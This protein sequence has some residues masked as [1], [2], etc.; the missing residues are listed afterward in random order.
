M[1]VERTNF[2]QDYSIKSHFIK[3]DKIDILFLSELLTKIY[4]NIEPEELEELEKMD[5]LNR[6]NR[7]NKLNKINQLD[8]LS[9]IIER[10][11]SGYN[12]Q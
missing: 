8:Q 12:Y 6:V 1:R 5:K 10:L 2:N 9:E 11:E 7:V 3:L 4:K